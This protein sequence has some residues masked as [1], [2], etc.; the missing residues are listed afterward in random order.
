MIKC[1]VQITKVMFC[2]LKNI[3][4]NAVLAAGK[5]AILQPHFLHS[6]G[7]L[8]LVNEGGIAGIVNLT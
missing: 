8:L 5:K 7:P 1:P 3:T 6:M 2:P 4:K